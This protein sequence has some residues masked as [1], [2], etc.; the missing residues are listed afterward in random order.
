VELIL[1]RHGLPQRIHNADGTPAD[2]AL[3]ADGVKQATL[4]AQRFLPG[5]IDRLYSSPMRRARETAAPLEHLLGLEAVLEPGI[6]EMDHQSDTYIPIDQLKRDDYPRWQALVQG[7]EL[8][9]GIDMPAFRATVVEAL[10]RAVAAHRGGRVA[11]VCHG[12]VVNAWAGHLLGVED[13]FFLD[14]AYT[15]VS[16]FLAASTGERSVM[17]LNEA[18]H[19]RGHQP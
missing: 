17:S 10:E 14:V 7:G 15:S 2:P 11:V 19:L 13:P 3:A 9:G 5:T 18:G 16:R 12:G 1:I 6:V 4:M 8:W